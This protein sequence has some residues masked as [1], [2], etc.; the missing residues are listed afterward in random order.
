MNFLGGEILSMNLRERYLEKS[1]LKKSMSKRK[2]N[3]SVKKLKWRFARN[4][5]FKI[6]LHGAT[7]DPASG[8]L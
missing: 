3:I 4:I 2:E 1:G 8:V 7:S 5:T 6:P